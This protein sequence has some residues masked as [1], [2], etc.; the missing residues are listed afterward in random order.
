MKC[1]KAAARLRL[2]AL[3]PIGFIP[4]PKLKSTSIGNSPVKRLKRIAL[5]QMASTKF[6]AIQCR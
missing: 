6:G 3:A 1:R 5:N 4:L 2:G